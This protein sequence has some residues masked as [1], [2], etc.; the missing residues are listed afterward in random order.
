MERPPAD[1]NPNARG[2]YFR[3][4]EEGFRS[5]ILAFQG[6]RPEDRPASWW[7]LFQ[8][9]EGGVPPKRYEEDDGESMIAN[10][11]SN[12]LRFGDEEIV[13][14]QDGLRQAEDEVVIP[15]PVS[16]QSL[17]DVI[18]GGEGLVNEPQ[19][20][21]VQY[22]PSGLAAL[23]AVDRL[24]ADIQVRAKQAEEDMVRRAASLTSY[25]EVLAEIDD[26]AVVLEDM[27]KSEAAARV[28]LPPPLPMPVIPVRPSPV[29]IAARR[30]ERRAP[31]VDSTPLA[32]PSIASLPLAPAPLLIPVNAPG[33]LLVAPIPQGDLLAFESASLPEPTIPSQPPKFII[34]PTSPRRE[35]RASVDSAPPAV[36]PLAQYNATR[37]RQKSKLGPDIRVMRGT[38]RGRDPNE[39]THRPGSPEAIVAL[40]PSRPDI[41]IA[42]VPL[43][44]SSPRLS[45]SDIR[46]PHTD[47][48]TTNRGSATGAGSSKGKA[49][50]QDFD[51]I[52]EFQ[53]QLESQLRGVLARLDNMIATLDRPRDEN[54]MMSIESEMAKKGKE[55]GKEEPKM[56]VTVKVEVRFCF[57]CF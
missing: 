11:S 41:P 51:F 48:R 14:V 21:S 54:R 25:K 1:A 2:Y 38:K 45:S 3:M 24:L 26:L 13:E 27:K 23:A 34:S 43:R 28:H 55:K 12:P 7:N 16:T 47:I 53:E 35:D 4:S 50:R 42:L 8:P 39:I 20:K 5:N 30:R 19:K 18:D 10:R 32:G 40:S 44:P 29:P 15:T 46:V 31:I 37:S 49:K 6:M 56:E 22:H 36:P 33:A 57:L 17:Q 9:R 52:D